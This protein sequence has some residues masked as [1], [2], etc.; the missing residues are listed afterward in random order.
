MIEVCPGKW[1]TNSDQRKYDRLFDEKEYSED[2]SIVMWDQYVQREIGLGR[3][4]VVV[5]LGGHVDTRM[6]W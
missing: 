6:D 2:V 3:P 4:N 5:T 1:G